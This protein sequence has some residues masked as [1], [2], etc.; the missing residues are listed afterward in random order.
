MKIISDPV[1]A[2]QFGTLTTIEITTAVLVYIPVAYLADRSTK[3]PFVVITFFFFSLFPLVLL[4]SQSLEWLI[5]CT[6]DLPFKRRT[7]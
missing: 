5:F 2:L 7:N 1:T 6:E 3:K 4:F